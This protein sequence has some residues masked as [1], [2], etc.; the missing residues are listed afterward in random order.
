MR[1]T[2]K[3]KGELEKIERKPD[4]IKVKLA[5]YNETFRNLKRLI[6]LHNLH[7]VCEEA[8][9]PNIGECWGHGTLTIMI[10]GDVCTRACRFCAVKTGDPKGIYD[11]FEPF[12][13]A[14]VIKKLNL[15]YVVI[16]SVDRDDLPDGGASV[17][18]D[19]VLR[20][21]DLCPN[22]T[23]ECL[24][25]DFNG[26]VNSLKI[27]LSSDP[28]VVGQNIETVRRLTKK[29]RDPRASYEKTLFVLEKVKE[30]SPH[31]VTKSGIILG[32]GEKEEEVL[33]TLA[34]LKKVGVE[35]VTLGQYL[36][37]SPRHLRVEEWIK[38]EKFKYF[39]EKAYEMGF[40][41]VFSG[42]LVR[43]SYKA[44]EFFRIFGKPS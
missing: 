36:R 5:N 20:I 4:W 28:H 37:P 1:P 30:I 6:K 17:Y 42:P 10:L 26:N 41:L 25:P 9:C 8:L 24:I 21:K 40:K 12:R 27:F 15:R 39:E 34:D 18:R 13:V 33:E 19:T 31:I 29:I 3:D 16:T 7:T 23:V 14:Y 2:I 35:I 32:L 44:W 22:I 43:S 38:P 11:P